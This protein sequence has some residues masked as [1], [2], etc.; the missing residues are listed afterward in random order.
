MTMY[1]VIL[2]NLV[3]LILPIYNHLV[4]TRNCEAETKYYYKINNFMLGTVLTKLLFVAIINASILTNIT[5][6]SFVFDMS[7]T[8]TTIILFGINT[9]LLCKFCKHIY[10]YTSYYV[11]S[12]RFSNQW[13]FIGLLFHSLIDVAIIIAYNFIVKLYT[14]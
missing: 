2:V 8:C 7:I 6:V 12:A 10:P 9:L 11:T 13:L 4:I 14:M 3:F 1:H 5:N